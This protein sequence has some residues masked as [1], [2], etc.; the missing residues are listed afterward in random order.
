[1]KARIYHNARCSKSRGCLQIL[2]ERGLEVEIVNYLEQPPGESELRQISSLSGLD[3]GQLMRSGDA[4]YR[5]L[6]LAEA[7]PEQLLQAL[8][9]HPQLLERPIVVVGAQA[10]VARPP[11]KVLEILP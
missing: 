3:F 10:V 8:L 5:E 2:Q 1:M 9:A 6:G 7:G 4:L 11:E